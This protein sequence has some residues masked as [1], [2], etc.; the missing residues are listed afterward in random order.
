MRKVSEETALALKGC[1]VISK[2]NTMVRPI[3]DEL[4]Y[5]LY[6]HGNQIAKNDTVTGVLYLYDCGW[7]SVTTKERL[8]AILKVFNVPA[9][10]YQKDYV[11]Y[12]SYKGTDV[13]WTGEYS[14]AVNEPLIKA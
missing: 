11:W 5:G 12:L 8:N 1:R 2:G 13:L 7:Q 4:L 10:I 3:I 9:Y 6:L 14:F